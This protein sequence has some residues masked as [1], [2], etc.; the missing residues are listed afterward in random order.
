MRDVL[1]AGAYVTIES[2]VGIF[3]AAIVP[4]HHCQSNQ[5]RWRER[6]IVAEQTQVLSK[7]IPLQA[8]RSIATIRWFHLRACDVRSF[9]FVMFF[10]FG[11][12]T[13][14]TMPG[15]SYLRISHRRSCLSLTMHIRHRKGVREKGKHRRITRIAFINVNHLTRTKSKRR[16]TTFWMGMGTGKRITFDDN[17]WSRAKNALIDTTS[18]RLGI[19]VGI[20]CRLWIHL[21]KFRSLCAQKKTATKFNCTASD[22]WW[23]A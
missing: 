19:I 13:G 18:H 20:R 1:R 17:S 3:A 16:F 11:E 9:S 21:T 5:L 14:A 7:G 6:A 2:D 23:I 22:A 12:W 15:F 10:F 4:R 8:A